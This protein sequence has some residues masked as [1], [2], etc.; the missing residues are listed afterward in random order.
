[1][2][3]LRSLQA[4]VLLLVLVFSLLAAAPARLITYV[5][6]EGQVVLQGLSGTLWEGRA[7][8]AMVRIPAGFAHLGSVNWSLSATSLLSLSPALAVES[9][10]GS[11]RFSGEVTS[12][13]E[14]HYW[15]ENVQARVAADLLRQFAPVALG[16]H[17]DL[18][19]SELTL[20]NALPNGGS[21]RIVWER[22]AW[23]APRGPIALGTYAL[24][25]TQPA[26]GPLS[27]TVLTLAGPLEADGRVAVTGR[28]YL[29]DVLVRSDEALDGQLTQALTLMAAPEGDGYRLKL[30]GEF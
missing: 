16:G 20:E 7:S 26:D 12:R 15:L 11:Q 4:I 3:S 23:Q 6:P 2:F 22:A 17:F 13:G 14:N 8:R 25:F 1:M 27:G 24:E 21:G 19:L 18:Q 10:W 5:L 9:R 29:V 28:E 30:D